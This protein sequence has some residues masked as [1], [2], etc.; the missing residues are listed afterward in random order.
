MKFGDDD[1][2]RVVNSRAQDDADDKNMKKITE[3]RNKIAK[4]NAAKEEA[5]AAQHEVESLEE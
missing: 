5:I 1:E 2:D 4:F 3:R